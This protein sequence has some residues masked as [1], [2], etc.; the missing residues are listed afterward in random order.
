MSTFQKQYRINKGDF[1]MELQVQYHLYTFPRTGKMLCIFYDYIQN[2]V[3]YKYTENGEGYTL[4][5]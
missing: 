2:V 5:A 3:K 1:R 4:H